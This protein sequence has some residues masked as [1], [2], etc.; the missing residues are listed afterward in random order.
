MYLLAKH[1]DVQGKLR[2]E[3][4]EVF[5]GK[6]LTHEDLK[7]VLSDFLYFLIFFLVAILGKSHQRE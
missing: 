7:K 6:E 5:Q 2:N 4:E 3:I 1:L